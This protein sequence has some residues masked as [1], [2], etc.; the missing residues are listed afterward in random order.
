MKVSKNKYFLIWKVRVKIIP[1]NVCAI[2]IENTVREQTKIYPGLLCVGESLQ[3]ACY[4][5]HNSLSVLTALFDCLYNKM[6]VITTVHQK[7]ENIN[8]K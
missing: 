7:K 3:Q 2:V 4:D 1:L 8:L 6:K 5:E